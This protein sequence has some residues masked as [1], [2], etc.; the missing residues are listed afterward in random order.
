VRASRGYRDLASRDS[1]APPRASDRA[2][3]GLGFGATGSV[4]LSYTRLKSDDDDR[5]RY[6]SL[7]YSISPLPPLSVYTGYSHDLDHGGSDLL[8]AGLSWS[9]GGELSA[10]LDLQDHD[11]EL[12]SG[13]SLVRPLSPDGGYGWNLH[14]QHGDD[15]DAA[16]AELAW[17]PG[18]GQIDA[19]V[20]QF[21]DRHEA[22]A[23]LEGSLVVVDRDLFAARRVDDAFA[24]ISTDGVAGVPVSLEN[25]PIGRT[26]ARGHYLLTGLNAWQPNRLSIDTL[27]LPAQV[28]AETVR[29]DAVP[30]A[31]RAVLVDFKLRSVR[32]A[33]VVLRDAGGRPLPLGSR[34]RYGDGASASVGYDGQ[35]YLEN[36]A[37]HNPLAA[38]TPEGDT[39][40][41][42]LEL[43]AG[44]DGLPVIELTCR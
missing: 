43:A 24:L 32:A 42:S 25:R 36:L 31:Q 37:V 10:G 6:A 13:A 8:F 26:D 12:R 28:Q 22:Y 15:G 18:W 17:R 3:L 14:A 7:Q 21:D 34:V 5:F 19:G 23:S 30:A 44:S 2:L 29:I 1:R 39:C 41:T 35:V 38:T 33:L 16:Q 40:R 20:R 4:S 9:F 27:D 11:G